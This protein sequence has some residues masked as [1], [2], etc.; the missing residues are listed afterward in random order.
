MELVNEDGSLIVKKTTKVKFTGKGSKY[1]GIA[2]LNAILSII[3][4]GL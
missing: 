3:T 2:I 4:L 1:F